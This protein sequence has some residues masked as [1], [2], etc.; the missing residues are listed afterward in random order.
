MAAGD[1]EE[2]EVEQ[3]IVISE[4]DAQITGLV[5]DCASRAITETSYYHRMD[6]VMRKDEC[7]R[8]SCA[9]SDFT[10]PQFIVSLTSSFFSII[11]AF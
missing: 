6:L 8:H 4:H 10:S 5:I 2:K 3:I 7:E 1:G 11:R 9:A